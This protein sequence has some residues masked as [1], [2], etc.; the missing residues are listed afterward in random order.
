M[1]YMSHK[2]LEFGLLVKNEKTWLAFFYSDIWNR[3]VAAPLGWVMFSPFLKTPLTHIIYAC[4][5]QVWPV[6]PIDSGLIWVCNLW[7]SHLLKGSLVP[8]AC[9]VTKKVPSY[10]LAFLSV[11]LTLLLSYGLSWV[12]MLALL[13]TCHIGRQSIYLSGHPFPHLQRVTTVS[14]LQG[15][16]EDKTK[17]HT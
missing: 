6:S 2:N 11:H 1:Y 16:C 13:H 12:W 3:Q 4:A 14:N 15:W 10:H 8:G 17:Q 7:P 5:R 9:K